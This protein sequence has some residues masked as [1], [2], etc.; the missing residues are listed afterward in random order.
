MPTYAYACTACDNRFEVHQAFTDDALTECPRCSGQVRKLFGSVGIVFKGSGFY[1]T[2]SRSGSG[3]GSTAA[4][5]PST[6]GSS[7]SSS[8]RRTPPRRTRPRRGLVVVRLV[9]VRLD[10]VG[11]DVRVVRLVLVRL[12]DVRLVQARGSR[13]L[14]TG[15]PVVHRS[16]VTGPASTAAP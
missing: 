7:D 16:P 9:V 12:V 14:L 1:R 5:T 6:S 13:L 15:T 3:S 8:G 10:V 11:F 4:A 2:D